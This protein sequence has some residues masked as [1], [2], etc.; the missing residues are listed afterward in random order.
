M[1]TFESCRV[2]SDYLNSGDEQSARDALIK[3]LDE[4]QRNDVSYTPLVNHL[5]HE[6]GLFPYLDPTSAAWYDRFVFEAFKVDVGE[7][8]PVTL[9]R[10]QSRLLF[11]LVQGKSIAVSAPTSF[12]K[13]FVVDAF[14]ASTRPNVVVII[15]PTVALADE[16]RRR[17]ERRFGRIYKVITAANQTVAEQ[18]IL[19]FPQERAL[20][21]LSSLESID[22]L[23]VDEFYKASK[24]FDPERAGSLLHAMQMLSRRA[25]QRYYLAPNIDYLRDSPLTEGME[26]LRLNF[27]TVFLEKTELYRSIGKDEEKKSAALLQILKDNPGKTLIYAGTYANVQKVSTLLLDARKPVQ[28]DLLDQFASWLGRSYEPNWSLPRLVARGIGV[29]T[30]QLHRSIS[31]I[32]IRLFEEPEGLSQLI[33]TSSII[34]GVNTSAE[35][36]V[37]W[38]NKSG[39][40]NIN[41]FTYKNIIGRSG[42]MFR[43]FIGKVF[44]LEQPPREEEANLELEFPDEMLGLTDRE[45]SERAFTP[46]QIAKIEQYERDMSALVGELNLRELQG[47]AVLQTMDAGLALKIARAVVEN[48]REWAS[49]R[50]L[51]FTEPRHWQSALYRVMRLSPAGWDAPW[52]QF[53]R[54]VQIAAHGWEAS[55]PEL[56]DQLDEDE[57]GVSEFFKL[58][59][60][61]TFKLPALLSD[62]ATLYSRAHP[63]DPMNLDVA[64]ARISHGFLPTAVFQLEEYG[65]PRMLARK[66]HDSAIL[67][68]EDPELDLVTA[69]RRFVGIGIESLMDQIIDLHPFERYLLKHFYEGIGG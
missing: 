57:V 50:N 1:D 55:I 7:A 32:Q 28:H 18:C 27:N 6:V 46:E 11:S 8:A 26:F 31:Q 5:I 66:I 2:V 62:V 22:I 12:G 33:S 65:L 49:L 4:M 9:H 47:Q 59:R 56:L 64:V 10:E 38:S 52:K 23:I 51:N 44:I 37:L 48:K 63:G 34:E 54:F 36:V 3:L 39:R 25:K 20:G 30:G 19:V 67:N 16:T 68:F 35:N 17:L 69:L 13:S 53:V 41:D 15:V 40:A 60:T 42:R 14:I 61:M 58:E 43:H 45:W 29:H 24:S 21:Y